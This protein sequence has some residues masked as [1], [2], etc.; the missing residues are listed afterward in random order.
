MKVSKEVCE[1]VDKLVALQCEID[2]MIREESDGLYHLCC[3]HILNVQLSPM[4]G[5]QNDLAE[6]E[7]FVGPIRERHAYEDGTKSYQF[8]LGNEA[9][10]VI[11]MPANTTDSRTTGGEADDVCIDKE[12]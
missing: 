5:R 11:I 10:G 9:L 4:E 1:L 7:A 8:M 2:D 6:L 3:G 12:A